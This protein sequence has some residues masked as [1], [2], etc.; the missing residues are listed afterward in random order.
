MVDNLLQIDQKSVATNFKINVNCIF[1]SE[2]RFTACGLIENAAQTCSAIVGQSFFKKDD[3][4]GDS[5]KVI[6]FINNVKNVAIYRLP[7]IGE[8]INTRADLISRL[9]TAAYTICKMR[10]ETGVRDKVISKCEI[11]LMIKPL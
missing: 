7:E 4:N 5:N 9:D 2:R 1:V 6:G 3:M 10:C 11:T 8:Q